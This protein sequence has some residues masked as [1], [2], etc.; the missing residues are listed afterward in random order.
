MSCKKGSPK[1]GGRKAG[2]PNKVT[3]S[4]RERISALLEEKWDD[5]EKAIE[6]IKDPEKKARIMLDL[7]QYSVPKLASV[8]YKDKDKPHTLQD[9]LDADSGLKTRK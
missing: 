8:E 1:T 4:M 5:L 9:E 7:M 6:D 2:T 3:A